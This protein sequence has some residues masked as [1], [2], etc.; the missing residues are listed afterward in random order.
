MRRARPTPRKAGWS[1]S[2]QFRQIGRDAIR[3]WN[4]GRA[5]L[6]R[7][8]ATRKGEGGRCQQWPMANGRCYWH[9][10]ATP[11]GEQFHRMSVPAS[12]EKL[13]A[14]LH[15][16]QRKNKRR[17]AWLA[18]MTPERRV[19]Y[20]AWVRTH[21]PG[22]GAARNA[23][24]ARMRQSAE[25]RALLAAGPSPPASGPES[26]RIETALAAAKAK[27]AVLE[28]RNAEASDN[29]DEGIFA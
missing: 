17:L 6:P 26:I 24:R 15:T 8:E 23:E 1:Q 7:C 21:Q 16:S 22:A 2:A 27:L 19:K 20:D 14:K 9:G 28:A 29:D 25:A 18:S 4:A 12:T 10:G 5:R 11:R 3:Q 13:D